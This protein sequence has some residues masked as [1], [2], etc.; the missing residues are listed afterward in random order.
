MDT[1]S[2]QP[3][4]TDTRSDSRPIPEG[5]TA[6]Y[7]TDSA[8]TDR[9]AL[10][11]ESSSQRETCGRYRLDELVG[12][13]GFAQV[14]RG[15]DPQLKRT[16]AIKMPRPDRSHHPD[17]VRQFLAEGQKVAAVNC[18]GVVQVYDVG[19]DLGQPYIVSEFK[20]GGHLGQRLKLAPPP[21]R[22]AIELLAHV[23]DALHQAHLKGLVHRDVKPSNIVLDR[24]GRPFLT[25]F[26]LATTE[27]EQLA[28]RAGTVGTLAYM[29]PEQ[30]R[31]ESN[32][33]D[34]RSDVYSLGVIL[35][36]MLTGRL[37]FVG[38][39]YDE[40][41]DQILN[42][43]P[44]P[45]R[46]IDDSIPPVLEEI[47]L[48]CLA[49][50]VSQR[51]STALDVA[52]QLRAYLTEAQV[53]PES[54][55]FRLRF[56]GVLVLGL[57]LLV[58]YNAWREY[59]KPDTSASTASANPPTVSTDNSAEATNNP[60]SNTQ[61]PP[62]ETAS[63]PTSSLLLLD[64]LSELPSLPVEEAKWRN[65]DVATWAVPQ[66]QN[67]IRVLAEDLLILVLGNHQQGELD[68]K[69]TVQ[70]QSPDCQAG[71]FFGYNRNDTHRVAYLQTLG[72]FPS[73]QSNFDLRSALHWFNVENATNHSDWSLY[74]EPQFTDLL[75]PHPFTLR[76]RDDEL[77]PDA[78]SGFNS[79]FIAR[80]AEGVQKFLQANTAWPLTAKGLYGVWCLHGSVT[81]SDPQL[82]GQP[83]RFV[84]HGDE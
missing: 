68:L 23:A 12:Q 3:S 53:Q 65:L 26:G 5:E 71:V 2:R 61:Q 37:P 78:D 27:W 20:E 19:T 52:Q 58:G 33:V 40:Y 43:Q 1:H 41:K 18:P 36:R 84:K 47:C 10:S 30:V 62:P 13:G 15:F 46:T 74:G 25:D 45:P 6:T 79:L 82:N 39:T 75:A 51:Y 64:P 81:F 35:Y 54:R 60:E 31:G 16:V 56:G 66:K 72:V 9:E 21:L 76:L 42:R 49:K 83:V 44:R 80:R 8:P 70:P 77:L 29:S 55:A 57:V 50:D 32:R 22:Q 73:E 34:P 69:V 4:L 17:L 14:W 11:T 63:G 28:E 38:E 59:T 67:S 24:D 48:K 7:L